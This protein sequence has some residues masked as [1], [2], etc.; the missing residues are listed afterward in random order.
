[1]GAL[2]DPAHLL[3]LEEILPSTAI[4]RFGSGQYT[5][6]CHNFWNRY[7]TSRGRVE[8]GDLLDLGVL[9]PEHICAMKWFERDVASSETLAVTRPWSRELFADIPENIPDGNTNPAHVRRI[10]FGK[11]TEAIRERERFM[12]IT[13]SWT[14]G[15]E[16]NESQCRL[17]ITSLEAIRQKLPVSTRSTRGTESLQAYVFLENTRHTLQLAI[18]IEH[19]ASTR[20]RIGCEPAVFPDHDAPG[21]SV[22]EGYLYMSSCAGPK[23]SFRVRV[24]RPVPDAQEQVLQCMVLA[25]NSDYRRL[26]VWHRERTDEYCDYY[27]RNN[28]FY[29]EADLWLG[30]PIFTR[31]NF[32]AYVEYLSGS[33]LSRAS[34]SE[35]TPQKTTSVS[36]TRR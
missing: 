30:F 8:I 28:V 31:S 1:M 26:S 12:P 35:G 34:Y 2:M 27:Y 16:P 33:A 36:D 23:C 10:L 4:H 24:P 3:P 13:Q 6:V 7:A 20:L 21:D 9:Y 18:E 19:A 17:T 14:L 29:S 22:I 11:I 5:T 25:Q 15:S 32:E